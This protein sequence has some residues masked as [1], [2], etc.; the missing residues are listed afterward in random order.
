MPSLAK[1]LNPSTVH[2]LVYKGQKFPPK[3]VIRWAVK[4]SGFDDTR[5]SL[6]GGPNTNDP[7]LALGFTIAEKNQH[8]FSSLIGEYKS[9][10]RSKGLTAEIYKWQLVK[11]FQG[12]PN[13]NAEDFNAEIRGIEFSNLV[14]GV[15]IG[16]AVKFP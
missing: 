12:R 8:L 15:G 16:A 5:Y 1:Q 6:S 2:D 11:R 9:I 4:L 7:L 14:Y 3:E 10:L 13:I